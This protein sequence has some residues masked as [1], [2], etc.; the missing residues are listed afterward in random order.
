MNSLYNGKIRMNRYGGVRNS[1]PA[2]GGS[3]FMSTNRQICGSLTLAQIYS[4]I[5]SQTSHIPRTLEEILILYLA[6]VEY[7]FLRFQI[8]LIF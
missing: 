8:N 5:A 6:S 2:L 1:S 3:L 4:A 7:V